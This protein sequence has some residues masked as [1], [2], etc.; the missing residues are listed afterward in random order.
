M[1]TRIWTN[2]Y[3]I[4]ADVD[5]VYR[6]Y[7]HLKRRGENVEAKRLRTEIERRVKECPKATA[8][9]FPL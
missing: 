1:T 8:S 4:A 3:L 7:R 5:E 6:Q 2:E 9:Q